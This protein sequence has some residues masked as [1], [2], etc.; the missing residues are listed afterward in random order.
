MKLHLNIYSL[1]L[2]GMLIFASSLYAQHN[3][4]VTIIAAYNPT[5]SDATRIRLNPSIQDTNTAKPELNYSISSRLYE[6]HF[7]PDSIK[8]AKLNSEPYSKLY[9]FLAKGGFGNYTTPYFEFFYNNLR[10]KQTGVGVHYLH[11]SSY[12]DI[13]GYAYPAFSTNQADIWFKQYLNQSTFSADVVYKRDV[14]HYYGFNP[15]DFPGVTDKNIKQRFSFVDVNLGYK[16]NYTDS[17]HLNHNIYF[18]FYNLGDVFK[19]TENCFKL[20]G[21]V[22]KNLKISNLTNRQTLG[23]KADLR[24]YD[25][26]NSSTMTLI[27]LNPFISTNFKQFNFLVGIDF[28]MA[29]YPGRTG[30]HTY[31]Q[32]EVQVN[33]IPNVLN[34]YGGIGGEL[35]TNTY[36]SLSDENPFVNSFN[37]IGLTNNKFMFCGGLKSSLSRNLNLTVSF[38]GS[39]LD[40]MPFYFPNFY[41]NQANFTNTYLGTAFGNTFLLVYDHVKLLNIK[42]ELAYTAGDKWNVMFFASYDKYTTDKQAKAWYKPAFKLGTTAYYNINDKFIL[43]G[44]LTA[45]T[46]AYGIAFDQN[47]QQIT[48]K[49]DGFTDLSFGA[50]YRYNKLWS[51]FLNLNN[52]AAQRYSLWYDYPSYRFN[53]LAGVTFSF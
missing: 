52:I 46:G 20:G 26:S 27:K 37:S 28:N 38:K 47:N 9:H 6:T 33:F 4:E 8:P 50:E 36:K 51:A 24:F 39:N 21:G 13:K 44:T 17:T 2:L 43:R 53:L 12:G 29:S 18:G 30:Y 34:V 14:V 15:S 5:I 22:D 3:E 10:S 42:A 49:L 1:L 40:S 11:L 23:I 31:P 32:A 45:R 16:S 41:L 48:K 7:T 19:T 35:L 25:N